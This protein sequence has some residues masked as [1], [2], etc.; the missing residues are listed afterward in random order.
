MFKLYS[1]HLQLVMD[2]QERQPLLNPSIPSNILSQRSQ[3]E[4]PSLS[5]DE[6]RTPYP[7]TLPGTPYRKSINWPSAYI[8]VVSRVIGSGI[9]ATPGSIV[10]SAGSIGLTLLV[11]LIGTILSAC[12][13]AVSM[14]FGCMLPRS[15]GEKVYLEYAYPRPRFLASSLITA[16]VVLLGFT[17][18]NCIIFSKYTLFAL[19]IEPTELQHKMLAVGLLTAITIVHGCFLKTGI[20]VQ[21]VLGWVKIFLIGAMSLTGIWVVFLQFYRDTDNISPVSTVG[22]S[23]SWDSI[24]E[25]SNWSWS[26]LSS[27][28]FKV[29]YS[30]AGLSNVNNVLSEV[31]DPVGIIKTVCPTALITAGGLYFLAN[32]SYFLVIPLEDI[33][34]NGELVGALLFQ[35]LFG[36]HVGKIFF[37]LAIA[38]SA[39][40]NVM[41]VTFAL[42]RVNQEIA[43]QGFLPWQNILSSSRPFGTPLGGLI[44]HYIPSVLVLALPPQGDVYNFILDLE[45]YPGQ[46]FSLAITVGLL[47]VRY[48]EPYLP[49]PFKA[50]LPAVWLR[51]VVCL[52]LLVAPFIPPPNWKGDVDFFYATYAIVGIGIV[53]FGVL[54]WYV[55]TVLLPRWG[56]YQLEEEK[57]ILADGTSIIK[58]VHLY[59]G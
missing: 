29:Y 48:R 22:S 24:W 52:V 6:F 38:I 55:W 13:L 34:N 11:W 41:V 32:L 36:D 40:G 44:V 59:D 28:L 39:A 23:L 42:A 57:E 16:Q 21:N 17:A 53:L 54:Y 50:W 46:M 37:P 19:S 27:A 7:D 1:N 15:G 49:R 58:L 10:K 47:L 14:E 35:R 56:G 2:I 8:L 5:S 4:A 45:G 9:F 18:S 51:V 26:P 25:G 33:K 12:G 31:H 30:Y 20:F 3:P 43:R